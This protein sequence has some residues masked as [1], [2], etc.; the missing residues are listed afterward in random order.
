VTETPDGNLLYSARS[1]DWVLKIAYRNGFGA[2]E[3]LW[4]L[5]KDGD[6]RLDGS[7]ADG[8]FSHQHDAEFEI[9]GTLTLFDNSNLRQEQNADAHSR[10]QVFRL[11]ETNRVARLALNAD[12]GGYAFALG[13]AERLRNG[14]Y[15]FDL[16]F[17]SDA[18]T[19]VVEVDASGS[20]VSVLKSAAPT[21]RSFRM[22]D[23]Y[24]R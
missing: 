11:D 14:N 12:L 9:D 15:V 19:Q 10:G 22:K 2:G 3:V 18:S 20:K 7:D 23:M 5:G 21:Y 1:Q 17:L 13:S 24:S 8:W 4:K 6:F 16:G